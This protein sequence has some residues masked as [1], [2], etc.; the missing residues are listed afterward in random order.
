MTDRRGHSCVWWRDRGAVRVGDVR[1]RCCACAAERTR[2]NRIAA[3]ETRFKHQPHRE[4]E[5]F[6]AVDTRAA[7]VR[8][9]W[10]RRCHGENTRRR[11]V[12]ARARRTARV[13]RTRRFDRAGEVCERFA[14]GGSAR[15][16][17][18]TFFFFG[19]AHFVWQW[20]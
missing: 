11:Q 3:V 9:T 13:E 6:V 19:V 7:R 5:A 20:C 17:W 12:V 4:A 14:R 8:D 1:R 16:T 2:F 18:F 10:S 15:G